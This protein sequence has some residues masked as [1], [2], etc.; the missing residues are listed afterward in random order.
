MFIAKNFKNFVNIEQIKEIIEYLNIT[1]DWRILKNSIWNSRT[2]PLNNI[3]NNNIRFIIQQIILRIQKIIYTEY[4]VNKIIYADS[5]DLCRWFPGTE[6]DPHCDD[7]SNVQDQFII[8]GHR[9]FG[10]I[11]YINNNYTGGRTYYPDHAYEIIPEVGKLAIH[12]ADCVHKHGVTKIED[13]IRYTIACFWTF[14]INK[15]NKF[16]EWN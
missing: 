10:T 16:I 2:I 3:S 6:Q 11:I 9:K 8:H 15:A 4:N 1:S 13:N 5:V 12:P 14:D 7:M